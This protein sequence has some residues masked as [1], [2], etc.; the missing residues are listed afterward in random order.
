[1]LS[2]ENVILLI[3]VAL[4]LINFQTIIASI[5]IFFQELREPKMEIINREEIEQSVYEVI[6]P[7]DVLLRS[8]GFEH[9]SQISISHMMVK[10][11]VPQYAFYYYHPL[12]GVHAFITTTPFKGCLRGSTVSYD[13]IYESYSTTTSYDCFAHNS[14]ALSDTSYTFDYY[15]GSFESAFE[16]HLIDREIEGEVVRY[17]P[18]N[19]EGVLNYTEYTSTKMIAKAIEEKIIYPI[20]N[21]YKFSTSLAFIRYINQIVKGY[22]RAKKMIKESREAIQTSQEEKRTLYSTS[23]QYLLAQ[24]LDEKPIAS[25]KNS[26][27]KIFLISMVTFVLFFGLI[28]IPW[29]VLPMII[30]V[31]LIHELGH[32]WTMRYFGY[33]DT[34]IFFIPL[35]GAAAKGEKD[36][37]TPFEEY[38]VSLAGPLPG[39]I[40]AIGIGF[41]IFFNP[42]LRDNELLKDYAMMSLFL[43]YINL[44]P[45]FP[46]D[47]GKI[48]QTLLFTRYPMAQFY[49]FL[50]SILVIIFSA[51][52]L[53]SV[54]LGIFAVLLIFSVNNHYSTS[55]LIQEVMGQDNDVSLKQRVIEKLSNDGRYKN[56]E[57]ITKVSM[58]KKTL[59]ILSMK[60]PSLLLMLFGLGF[61]LLIVLAPFII[62]LIRPSF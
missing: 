52:M 24:Q 62:Q 5:L 25:S 11:D 1:M 35:F 30:V 8:L 27:V 16:K 39:M 48:V 56:E 45:I 13:S 43:N 4:L 28:G 40:I 44:L 20:K 51:L 14:M 17:Q 29:S 50:V 37:A 32:F 54:L 49:F 6:K 10:Y 7:Y 15:Y 47:G 26:K 31:L 18:F 33:Q 9:Q 61:Y 2:T 41:I 59:K 57:L 3:I 55:K 23:E 42:E 58:A 36:N 38:L 46:L 19:Q 60:K 21:G 22:K 34:S 12:K 53:Q